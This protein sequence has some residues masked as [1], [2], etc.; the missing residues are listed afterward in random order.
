MS[1]EQETKLC[2]HCQ[3]EIPKKA[4][5][6]PNCRK[7][8]GGALKWIILAVIVLGL[9]GACAGGGDDEKASDTKPQKVGETSKTE[10]SEEQQTETP[11]EEEVDSEFSVGEIVETSYLRISY[12]SAEEY[13][14]DNEFIQPKDGHV[15]YKMDFEFENISD[16]DKYVSSWDFNC[17]ADGYDMEQSYVLDS[18]DLDATL[19]PGKKTKGAVVFEVPEDAESVVLEYETNF[20]TENKIVFV[21]K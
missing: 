21:V 1:N 2:K 11:A 14:S 4:K 12:I 19:S 17:Y 3:S 7:K 13:V 20:W 5:V 10:Q 16:S 6:C 9:T 18:L 15:F 8:Q